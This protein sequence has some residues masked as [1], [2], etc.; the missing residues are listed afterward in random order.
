MR[1][2]RTV[3][4]IL[5]AIVLFVAAVVL[6]FWLSLPRLTTWVIGFHQQGVTRSLAVW[7]EDAANITNDVSAIH[8]AEM[9]KYMSY[10]YVPGAGYRGSA[11]VEAALQLQRRK[12]IDLVATS[13]ERYTGLD[14]G[15]NVG[16]WT[17][18]AK[19]R[20]SSEQDA[21]LKDQRKSE[22]LN[23]PKL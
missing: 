12:S 7:A 22:C 11:E 15:A 18:W 4:N 3:K 23:T 2:S 5:A 8:A 17:E 21:E 10:Y 16:L 13:L 14:Y 1:I 9:L 19:E 6:V 20:K